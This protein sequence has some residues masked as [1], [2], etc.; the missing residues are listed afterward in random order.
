MP[1]NLVRKV[2]VYDFDLPVGLEHSCYCGSRTTSL[3]RDSPVLPS[4]CEGVMEVA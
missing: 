3:R 2:L 4:L 1:E